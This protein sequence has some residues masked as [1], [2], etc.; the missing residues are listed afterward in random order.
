[1]NQL[2]SL[3][4]LPQETLLKTGTVDRADWNYRPILGWIQRQRFKL[5]V[6]FLAKERV[7]RLLEIGYGSG[8]FMPELSQHCRELYGIDIHRK[9]KSVTE[10]LA[11]LNVPAQLYSASATLLPFKNNFFDCLVAVSSLEFIDNLD[12]ACWEMQRVLKPGGCLIVVTPGCSKLVDLGLKILTGQSAKTD[13]GDRRKSLLPTLGK[14]FTIES[15]LTVPRFGSNFIC[16][17]T[18][19]KLCPRPT[20]STNFPQNLPKNNRRK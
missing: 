5:I 19:L 4:I 17:Y 1:M 14:Y 13:Y 6:S 15:Q 10:V 12:A 7:D 20:N 16:L 3:R 9:Q 2:S 18:G 8:V 11:K